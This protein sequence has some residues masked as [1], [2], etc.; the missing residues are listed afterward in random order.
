[1]R[2]NVKV[3][4]FLLLSTALI[5]GIG[6]KKKK[7]DDAQEAKPEEKKVVQALTGTPA[8]NMIT[9]FE[10]GV[11]AVKGGDTAAAATKLSAVMT[12][13]DVADVRARSKAAKGT[14]KGATQAEKDKF[15]A[16][17]KEYKDLA[18]KLDNKNAGFLTAHKDWSK[19]WGIK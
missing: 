6:C 1:M 16:L 2:I 17:N 8:Q 13:Y 3:L 10:M 14:D 15:K 5:I 11:T 4:V 18:A 9:V 12:D 7:A 19:A